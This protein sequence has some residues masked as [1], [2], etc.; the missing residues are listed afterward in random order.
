[1]TCG[2]LVLERTAG[3]FP[4]ELVFSTIHGPYSV[5]LKSPHL[6]E[7]P[8]DW[9]VMDDSRPVDFEGPFKT[10][11][12]ATDRLS[13]FMTKLLPSST[14]AH[15]VAAAAAADTITVDEVPVA[16]PALVAAGDGELVGMAL[17]LAIASLRNIRRRIAPAPSRG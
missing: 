1:M 14:E 11:D 3:D 5:W 4:D 8:W 6:L 9:I 10:R 7:G 16:A 15:P 2:D 17:D 13:T 12:E